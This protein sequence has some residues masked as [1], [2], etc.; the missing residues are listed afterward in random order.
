MSRTRTFVLSCAIAA[1]ASSVAPGAEAALIDR[2]LYF[3]ASAHCQAALPVF[4]GLI[5]KR[6]LAV[7]NEGDSGAFVTCAIPTQDRLV[8]LEVFAST[9]D[10]AARR[11]SC[12]AVSGLE[13]NGYYASRWVDLPASGERAS[14]FWWG[15]YYGGPV[16]GPTGD[17]NFFIGPY[18]AVTCQLPPATALNN[19]IVT[20]REEIGA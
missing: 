20:Y 14:M 16:A 10:G 13:G 18:L 7:V 2:T 17:P 8:T 5:R 12:T 11:L 3:N 1:V 9:R 19:F 15:T 6:P 4:D